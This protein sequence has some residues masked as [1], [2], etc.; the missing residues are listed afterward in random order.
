[1]A[2]RR[3]ERAAAPDRG[4]D[5]P[6]MSSRISINGAAIAAQKRTVDEDRNQ[7]VPVVFATNL[8][9][10]SNAKWPYGN[11]NEIYSE[12]CGSGA[13]STDRTG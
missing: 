10:W 7:A 9:I 11:N 3:P 4:P 8:T 5:W 13:I 1:M 2:G 6:E 12:G